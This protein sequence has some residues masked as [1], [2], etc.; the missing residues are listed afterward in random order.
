MTEVIAN[1]KKQTYLVRRN[2]EKIKTKIS[3]QFSSSL[4]KE[5]YFGRTKSPMKRSSEVN[6]HADKDAK[7]VCREDNKIL[8]RDFSWPSMTSVESSDV[9]SMALNSATSIRCLTPMSLLSEDDFQC[10]ES[11]FVHSLTKF[12]IEAFI[13]GLYGVLVRNKS[14]DEIQLSNHTIIKSGTLGRNSPSEFIFCLVKSFTISIK[15]QLE[16]CAV[17]YEQM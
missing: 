16:T 6:V 11:N 9:G 8:K 2:D 7:I 3:P 13:R 5:L 12:S 15:T 10:A 14:Y 1:L 17:W 4:S